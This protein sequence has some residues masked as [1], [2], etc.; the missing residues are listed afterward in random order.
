MSVVIDITSNI[1]EFRARMNRDVHKI[2]DS[3]TS[4]AL[5]RTVA[6]MKTDSR[7]YIAQQT[8]IKGTKAGGNPIAKRIQVVKARKTF[9]VA[10]IKMSRLKSREYPNLIHFS[11]KIKKPNIVRSY[12]AGPKRSK[13]KHTFVGKIPNGD[14]QLAWHRDKGNPTKVVPKQGRYKGRVIKRGPHKGQK[15][16]RQPIKPTFGPSIM[17]EFIKEGHQKHMKESASNRFNKEFNRALLAASKRTLG[18][19][20]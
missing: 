20:K 13:I 4:A 9:H 11:L 18:K 17:A 10:S 15:L 8:K 5:N 12:L 19:S 16:K 3:A 1:N 14:K 2:I 6:G 7:K